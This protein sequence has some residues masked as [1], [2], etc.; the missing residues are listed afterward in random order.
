MSISLPA[1][2]LLVAAGVS[3]RAIYEAL[4]E[5]IEAVVALYLKLRF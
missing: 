3:E 5:F 2:I 1:D 4:R